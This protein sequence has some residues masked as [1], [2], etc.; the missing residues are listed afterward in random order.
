MLG[1]DEVVAITRQTRVHVRDERARADVVELA[2]RE[3]I[4]V[5]Y[6]VELAGR[7]ELGEVGGDALAQRVRAARQRPGNLVLGPEAEC[8]AQV[9]V[10]MPEHGEQ[11]RVGDRIV[12]LTGGDAL[13]QLLRARVG[14]LDP[15]QRRQLGAQPL[16]QRRVRGL[17]D[18]L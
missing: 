5:E 10:E 16:E 2:R 7:L 1:V 3:V 14:I 18:D 6:L 8:D 11:M 4:A 17:R 15:A 9:R 12:D 13:D